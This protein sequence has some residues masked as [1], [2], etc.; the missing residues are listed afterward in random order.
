[1]VEKMYNIQNICC[2]NLII[3]FWL[4]STTL[5]KT[6]MILSIRSAFFLPSFSPLNPPTKAPLIEPITN[7]LAET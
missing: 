5:P 6:I 1:M 7:T 2:L 3:I 4:V